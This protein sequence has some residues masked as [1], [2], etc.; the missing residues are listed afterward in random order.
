MTCHNVSKYIS[1]HNIAFLMFK[2]GTQQEK[3]PE[4]VAKVKE[5][6]EAK[7][8]SNGDVRIIILDLGG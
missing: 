1:A 2:P 4:V 3:I 6:V 5:V 8:V 7:E